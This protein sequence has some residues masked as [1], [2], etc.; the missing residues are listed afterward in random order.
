MQ[1][2]VILIEDDIEL[3]DSL[4][5]FLSMCDLNVQ[6][7]GSA[8]DFYQTL[9]SH[10]YDVAIIDVS[11]PDQSGYEIAAYLRN[12][13]DTGIVM[14]TAKG[15]LEDRLKGYEAGA[16]LYF[17]KPVDSKELVAAILSLA[18]RQQKRNGHDRAWTFDFSRW[19]LISP[20]NIP[21]KLTSKEVTFLEQI[22]SKPGKTV[23]RQQLMQELDYD[24]DQYENRSLDALVQR[25][26]RKLEKETGK[27][28]PIQTV[29]ATGY[30]FSAPVTIT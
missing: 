27:E 29:H 20:D 12:Q 28:I 2:K 23:T 21:V 25:L 6:G 17:V 11:L 4:V 30:C 22:T 9:N 14:L 18:D 26:R 7:V 15:A 1:P 5:E 8:I 24:T 10:V 16:D 19:L 13:T 3:R